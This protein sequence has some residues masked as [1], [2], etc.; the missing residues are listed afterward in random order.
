MHFIYDVKLKYQHKLNY[1]ITL[2]NILYM[3]SFSNTH[4]HTF[5]YNYINVET[6][7]KEYLYRI[8]K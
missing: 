1:I 4:T 8:V 3:H 6:F 2:T 7:Y 5:V